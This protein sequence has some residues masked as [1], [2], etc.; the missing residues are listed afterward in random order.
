MNARGL[1][2]SELELL[3]KI[4]SQSARAID[5]LRQ[6]ERLRVVPIDEFGSLHFL[7][8][9]PD[10]Q[11]PRSHRFIDV[12]GVMYD[13]D[14]IPVLLCPFEDEQGLLYMFDVQKMGGGPIHVALSVDRVHVSKV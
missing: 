10:L 2:T 1:A 11:V 12:K 8:S 7:A 14:G 6:L 9:D 5:Y 4:L 3:T 13:S